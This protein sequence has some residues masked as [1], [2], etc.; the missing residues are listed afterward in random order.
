VEGPGNV[1]FLIFFS[2]SECASALKCNSK[3]GFII[4][5]SN[6]IQDDMFVNEGQ[7]NSYA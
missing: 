6:G 1:F 4:R 5:K 7:N 3:F 2:L